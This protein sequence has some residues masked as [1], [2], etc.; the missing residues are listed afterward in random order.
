M[1]DAPLIN[2]SDLS[3]LLRNVLYVTILAELIYGVHSWQ[4]MGFIDQIMASQITDAQIDERADGLDQ[5]GRLIGFGYLIMIAL[6][7]LLSA[8]WI[9][10]ASK[11]AATLAPHKDRISPGWAV[12][13]YLV[14][15]A[16]LFMPYQ[17]MRQT[18]NGS[19]TPPAELNAPPPGLFRWWW[20][21]WLI[22]GVLATYS[23]RL[24]MDPSATL[25]A[26][27][28]STVLDIANT[29]LS[30]I[31]IWL[32]LQVIQSVT[33][34]QQGRGDPAGTARPLSEVAP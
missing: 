26:L 4:L 31:S 13:W 16:N 7:F 28:L 18:Y 30:V 32:W 3:R 21:L 1:T 23:F 33:R 15:F 19:L 25:E 12:G 17:A 9:M 20:A 5:M 29:P 2:L 27:K 22:T 6:C 14:P 24:T 11:N 8:L 34:L 10:R